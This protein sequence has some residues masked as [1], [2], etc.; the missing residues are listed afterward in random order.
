MVAAASDLEK[1]FLETFNTG[2]VDALMALYWNSP[3]L[4]MFP[5]DAMAIRGWDAAKAAM[6]ETV[7]AMAGAKFEILESRNVAH[8]TVVVGS[9]LW[10]L[11]IPAAKGPA[12]V[13]EGR[14]SDVKAQKDG[15]WV[16]VSDHASVPLPPPPTPAKK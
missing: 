15:K 16:F 2:D 6:T 9:G 11:T 8:G 14:Y 7:K 5:P 1:R 12:T 10:K 4:S 3:D 13:L